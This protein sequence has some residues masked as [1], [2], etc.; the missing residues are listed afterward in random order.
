MF[1]KENVIKNILIKF[2]GF[3]SMWNDHMNQYDRVSPGLCLD[4]TIFSNY[5][6]RL[7]QEGSSSNLNDI[8][9]VVEDFIVN[10]DEEVGDAITTCFLENLINVT[11]TRISADSYINLLGEKSKE[12][13]KAWD[14]FTGIKT[15]GLW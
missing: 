9:N 6:I 1:T 12:Y 11:G 10:G 14:I 13:C 5:V 3:S 2:P 15:N 8:F 7:I 4:I